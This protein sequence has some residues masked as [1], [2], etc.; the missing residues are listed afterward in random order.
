[1]LLDPRSLDLEIRTL[2]DQRSAVVICEIVF[3]A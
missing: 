1:M 3:E 2:S